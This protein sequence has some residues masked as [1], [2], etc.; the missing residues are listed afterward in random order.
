MQYMMVLPFLP[1]GAHVI[2][3]NYMH[4]CMHIY[5]HTYIYIHAYMSIKQVRTSS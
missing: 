1:E 4:T 3:I 5:A 2:L